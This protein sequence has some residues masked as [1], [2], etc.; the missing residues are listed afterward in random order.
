MLV[1]NN[2]LIYSCAVYSPLQSVEKQGEEEQEGAAGDLLL[3]DT[4]RDANVLADNATSSTSGEL[5]ERDQQ[6]PPG[7]TIQHAIVREE[8]VVDK[9]T[10]VAV[11]STCTTTSTA[12][13]ALSLAAEQQD[14]VIGR[15]RDNREMAIANSSKLTEEQEAALQQAEL[16][17]DM[18]TTTIDN[19]DL[20]EDCFIAE[21]PSLLTTSSVPS[22][23][24]P[25][26]IETK[27]VPQ[28]ESLLHDLHRQQGSSKTTNKPRSSISLIPR[29]SSSGKQQPP[30]TADVVKKDGRRASSSFIP[31]LAT[32]HQHQ[33]VMPTT[34]S[35][36]ILM[37]VPPVCRWSPSSS[38][39]RNSVSSTASSSS[40]SSS[41][42]S[43]H[44]HQDKKPSL[45]TMKSNVPQQQLQSK[46][47][48]ATSMS[49]TSSSSSTD[50]S[51]KMSSGSSTAV[52]QHVSRL[53]TKRNSTLA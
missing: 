25:M 38:S 33:N 36:D 18:C 20:L 21:S 28:T 1:D 11:T 7:T 8:Q 41:R 2:K 14:K 49:L 44:N 34:T 22:E 12:A 51:N 15:E 37:A 19:Q 46:I 17:V 6:L 9:E 27:R 52:P 42:H 48:K 43:Q 35:K 10:A 5:R 29:S 23:T 53:P 16:P 40:S 4:F 31:V 45:H 26:V 50:I 39:E 24:A 47:P 13:S 3:N 32:R 30:I